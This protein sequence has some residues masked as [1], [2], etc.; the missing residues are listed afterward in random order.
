MNG[1]SSAAVDDVRA[2]VV[3]VDVVVVGEVVKVM[4]RDTGEAAP[5][6]SVTM[7]FDCRAADD[8][9]GVV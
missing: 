3:I 2:V 1:I 6:P 5:S 4:S 7:A 8:V 9:G